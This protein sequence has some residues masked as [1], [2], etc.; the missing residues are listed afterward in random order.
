VW[1]LTKELR[2]GVQ[3]PQKKYSAKSTSKNK[4]QNL[5][6]LRYIFTIFCKKKFIFKNFWLAT[7]LDL[8]GAWVGGQE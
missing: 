5:K 3:F 2:N 7:E 8:V 6:A 1:D 4:V